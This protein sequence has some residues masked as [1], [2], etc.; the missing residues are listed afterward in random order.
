MPLKVKKV[1]G[2]TIA[3]SVLFNGSNQYLSVANT[4]LF[5]SGSWTFECWINAPV[6][7]TD[8]PIIE[9]R[10]SA[11]GVG[12]STGFTVTMITPTEIRLRKSKN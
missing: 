7:Q 11:G 12:N 8:K 4:G 2:P 10:N 5:G 6:G 1:T 3:A 9:A